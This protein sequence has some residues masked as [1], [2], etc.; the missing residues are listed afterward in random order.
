MK[1]YVIAYVAT[2]TLVILG[3]AGMG[4][5]IVFAVAAS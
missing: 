3:F 2:W 5:G 1:K 4:A